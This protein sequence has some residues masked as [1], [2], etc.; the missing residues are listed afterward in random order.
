MYHHKPG[1]CEGEEGGIREQSL[2]QGLEK[3]LGT[4][5]YDNL[6]ATVDPIDPGLLNPKDSLLQADVKT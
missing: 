3:W 4:D 5:K 6:P 1:G 2:W